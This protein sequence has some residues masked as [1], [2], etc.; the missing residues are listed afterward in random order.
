MKKKKGF[1]AE[2]IVIDIQI[3]KTFL[4]NVCINNQQ[5][6]KS[7]FFFPHY[8]LHFSFTILKI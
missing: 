7:N 4:G 3:Y 1:R 2:I 8:Y 6:K 5:K